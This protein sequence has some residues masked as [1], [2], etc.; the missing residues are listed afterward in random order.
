VSRIARYNREFIGF[1]AKLD[2]LGA[3]VTFTRH[4]LY[5]R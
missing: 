2:R 3:A 1:R 5:S 4:A